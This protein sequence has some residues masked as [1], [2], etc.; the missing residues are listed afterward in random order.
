MK[1]DDSIYRTFSDLPEFIKLNRIYIHETLQDEEH[2]EHD[3]HEEH[4]YSQAMRDVRQI[5]NNDHRIPKKTDP[6]HHQQDKEETDLKKLLEKAVDKKMGIDVTNLPEYM[7]GYVEGINP[8]SLDKL[9]A[10][11]FSVEKTLDLH[12]YRSDEACE[13]FEAFIKGA[14]KEGAH[15]VRV[16]HGRGLKSKDAPVLKT[17]LKKWIVRA[18]HRKWV[19]AFSSAQM[20]DGGPGATYILLKK[21]PSKKHMHIIG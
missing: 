18:M 10:G 2:E 17:H 19:V 6:K 11:E 15:C 12:G 13:L 16:V 14:I 1:E 8:V 5:C 21:K 4:I 7:E 3:E 20:R 9:R